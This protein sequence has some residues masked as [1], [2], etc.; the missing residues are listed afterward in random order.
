[1]SVIAT[2]LVKYPTE[3]YDELDDMGFEVIDE[4][5]KD[6]INKNKENPNE[7]IGHKQVYELYNKI[8]REKFTLEEQ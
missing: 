6:I 2:P 8:V 7:L 3:T 4:S 1:M 5:A